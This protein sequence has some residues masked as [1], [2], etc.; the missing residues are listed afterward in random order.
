M[1]PLGAVARYANMPDSDDPMIQFERAVKLRE[2]LTD[3]SAPSS[4]TTRKKLLV[5]ACATP[6]ATAYPL[7]EDHAFTIDRMKARGF[8]SFVWHGLAPS[9]ARNG[10]I[11]EGDDVFFLHKDEVR[12]ALVNGGDQR[13]DQEPA[14]SRV[15]AALVTPPDAIGI[16]PGHRSRGLVDPVHHRRVRHLHRH[17][18]AAEGLSRTEPDRRCRRF[19]LACT[20]AVAPRRALVER[21]RPRGRRGDEHAG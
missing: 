3:R 7:T 2:E 4:R 20:P 21:G 17:Q 11:A 8:L 10:V 1:I 18:A 19:A 13:G 5:R 9:F 16:L 15:Q 14:A 12:D 6:P